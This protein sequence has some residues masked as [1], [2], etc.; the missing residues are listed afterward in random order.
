MGDACIPPGDG[1]DPL[2]YVMEVSRGLEDLAPAGAHRALSAR[3]VIAH[4]VEDR[5]AEVTCACGQTAVARW[6]AN[7]D[8]YQHL[9]YAAW[10]TGCG[11]R[12]ARAV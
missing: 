4:G 10:E 3:V 7:T 1:G 5:W 12:T 11:A 8:G 9:L 2:S 6:S